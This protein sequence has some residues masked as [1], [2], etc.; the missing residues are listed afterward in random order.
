[1]YGDYKDRFHVM[2]EE[3]PFVINNF[4]KQAKGYLKWIDDNLWDLNRMQKSVTCPFMQ[5]AENRHS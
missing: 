4:T 1:M 5:A 2:H 3:N